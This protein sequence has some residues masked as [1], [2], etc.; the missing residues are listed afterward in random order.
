MQGSTSRMTRIW[1]FAAMIMSAGLLAACGGSSGP[2]TAQ[3][4]LSKPN[5]ANLKDAHFLVTGKGNNQ[6]A[7][8]DINGDGTI[9]YK[10]PGA[11]RFKFQTSVAGQQVSFEDISINGTDYTFT[12]P[13]NGKWTATTTSTGL[14]PTSFTGASEFKY[15]GEESLPNGKA[16]HAR[17]KDKDGNQFDGWIRE[18]DGYPLK[19]QIT[20]GSAQ[21]TNQL[22]L[23]FDKYNTGE[24]ITAP[25]AS[26]V[27]QG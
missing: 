23:N 7:M 8:V 27:V 11:G 3:D 16:W 17:A 12:V 10:T 14:G 6:G 19:Y 20:Q 18:S 21:G 13:G 9:V 5:H 22:T 26:Q 24:S 25:P 4:V 15:V 2:P 1:V